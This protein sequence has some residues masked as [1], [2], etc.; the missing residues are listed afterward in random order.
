MTKFQEL[1]IIVKSQ[2]FKCMV[3]IRN[4]QFEFSNITIFWIEIRDRNC[5]K[6][7]TQQTTNQSTTTKQS[8]TNQKPKNVAP[9]LTRCYFFRPIPGTSINVGRWCEFGV[10]RTHEKQ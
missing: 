1:H 6:K 2:E 9:A 7:N 10:I 3:F 8:H 4:F 5:H